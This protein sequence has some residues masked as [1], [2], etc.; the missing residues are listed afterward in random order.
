MLLG[1]MANDTQGGRSS[2]QYVRAK[3]TVSA[4]G[5]QP[6]EKYGGMGAQEGRLSHLVP[7]QQPYGYEGDAIRCARSVSHRTV[8]CCAI[9]AYAHMLIKPFQLYIR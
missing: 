6:E 1:W 2:D 4:G 7:R 5:A 3:P 9:R 8:R